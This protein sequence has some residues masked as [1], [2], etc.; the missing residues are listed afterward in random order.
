MS[1]PLRIMVVSGLGKD[2]GCTVR[3]RYLT[4]A[5][6]KAGA[7]ARLAPGLKTLPLF[8]DQIAA[9]A[10]NLRLLS[11]PCDV[12]IGCKPQPAITPLLTLKKLQGATT[13]MDIDDLDFGYRSGLLRWMTMRV[14]QPFPRLCDLVT[15]HNE[16]LLE[17]IRDVFHVPAA[18]LFRLPQAVDTDIFH[19]NVH[20]AA[21]RNGSVVVYPAHLNIASDL[22]AV[23]DVIRLARQHLP[24]LQLVVIG[25]GPKERHFRA[26]AKAKNV[27]DITS[28]TGLVEP[29]CVPKYLARGDIGIAYYKDNEV[30]RF[31]AS[32]KVREMLA[33]GLQV[34]CTDVG[35]L[36]QFARFTYQAPP[37]PL[38]V[39]ATLVHVLTNGGDG[40]EVMGSSYVR[41]ALAWT[42][43]GK[44]LYGKLQ[45]LCNKSGEMTNGGNTSFCDLG[46][47]RVPHACDPNPHR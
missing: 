8:L 10:W 23:F 40:R 43:I 21:H 13:V 18:R 17:V 14:Q 31:R 3:A 22:D 29:E 20:S 6:R 11:H 36:K 39:S 42:T 5:L 9:S 34:V 45:T 7:K 30:N 47:R 44:L 28:F 33:C 15:Y 27:D 35:D 24:S 26:L 41:S 38:Q 1:D 19:P 32:M 2:S 4:T 25:G 12:V 46:Q 37:E 16:A